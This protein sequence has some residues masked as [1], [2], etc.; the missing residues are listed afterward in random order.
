MTMISK[1]IVLCMESN[2][3]SQTD[4]PYIIKTLKTFYNIKDGI[5]FSRCFM[6]GKGNYNSRAVKSQISQ[7][8]SMNTC[9]C[10]EVVYFIDLDNYISDPNDVILNEDIKRYCEENG[11]KLVWFCKN[12]EEVYWHQQVHDSDKIKYAKKFNQNDNLQLATNQTLASNAISLQK[13][14]FLKIF[15]D[16]LETKSTD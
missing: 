16:L 15:N 9:E 10:F 11:Y 4:Y 13:S 8:K 3:K 14:N 1:H 12:I 2:N 6:G 5:Y 7:L